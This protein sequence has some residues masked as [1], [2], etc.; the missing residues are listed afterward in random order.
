MRHHR[1]R[2]LAILLLAAFAMVVSACSTGDGDGDA[3]AG[4]PTPT[5]EAADEDGGSG[6]PEPDGSDSGQAND[7]QDES[8]GEPAQAPE[9]GDDSQETGD[10]A[11]EATDELSAPEPTPTE[12]VRTAS[13]RGVTADTIDI[14]IGFWNTS[15]F[16]FGFFGDP[17]EVWAALTDAVNARGGIHGRSLVPTVA[18]F[19]PAD[20]A[21]MLA[22]CIA[23]TEDAEVFAVL[24]G[25]RGDANYCV[26]EQHET[27][28][29][30]SQVNAAGE[31]LE[32]ARAPIAGIFPAGDV[33]EVALIEA[34]DARGWFDDTDAVGVHYDGS[35]TQDR[36]GDAVEEALRGVG[37]EVA[38][39]MNIDD[40]A[41][42]ED[43]LES[44][45]EIMQ[46]QARSAG[47]SHMVI[48]GA[49]A[50]GLITYGDLG[51]ALAA[52]D[53]DNFTT[54]IQ[55]GIDPANLDGTISTALRVNL[56]TD[57]VDPVT[58]QCLDDVQAALPEAR[59][60][61]PGPGVVNNADDPNYWNYTVLACR[62]LELF[63]QAAAAAG[64]ELTN[65]SFRAGLESLTE[66]SL[67]Q[68]PFA[69]FGPDKFNGND[70]FRLVVFDADADEDG[71]LVGLGDPIDLTP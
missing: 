35:G 59:F 60:E 32:R 42:D 69:S 39:R 37:V 10:D 50:T 43:T 26:F 71:E 18:D 16:G 29:I 28:H 25:M 8:G 51:I 44:Q 23:L 20:N 38:L 22:A 49:A 64:V 6:D 31:A 17:E 30:G 7:V 3:E 11:P 58:Q 19:N 47:I 61:R 9:T 34:L 53:S 24:G 15:V 40:L 36:V 62:D 2:H 57:P 70:T 33:R 54:A 13:F 5:A 14:G 48:I 65:Q 27:I 55:Q 41:L 46:E 66:L 63:R 52:V 21:G 56:P 67:P 1:F 45:T 4:E 12:V 68:I